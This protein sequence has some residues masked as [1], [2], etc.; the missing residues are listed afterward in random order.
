MQVTGKVKF[1]NQSKGY[2]FIAKD[3]GS[4]DVFVHVSSLPDGCDTMYENQAVKFE[5]ES[6]K[7]GLRAVNVA[8]A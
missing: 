4:G 5:V 2:G 7:R 1:F 6:S 3:D 8:L